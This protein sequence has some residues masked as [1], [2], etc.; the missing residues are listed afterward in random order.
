MKKATAAAVIFLCIAASPLRAFQLDD[1]TATAY[2]EFDL[3]LVDGILY[4]FDASRSFIRIARVLAT[5]L[6]VV[7]VVWNAFRLWLGTEQVRKACADIITKFLIFTA[8]FNLY[9][10]AVDGTVNMA[11]NIGMTAGGGY[12]YLAEEY[13]RL[14]KSC[15]AKVDA[16]KEVMNAVIAQNKDRIDAIDDKALKALADLTYQDPADLAAF[17]GEND[18]KAISQEQIDGA[19]GVSVDMNWAKWFIPGGFAMDLSAVGWGGRNKLKSAVNE[20]NKKITNVLINQFKEMGVDKA[21]S[22]LKAMEEVFQ[23][24]ETERNG[25]ITEEYFYNPYIKQKQGYSNLISPGAMI[26]SAAVI[27][28]I[29]SVKESSYYD[30]DGFKELN[31]LEGGIQRLLHFILLA[32]MSFGVIAAVVFF[33]VQYV[34]CIFEYFIVSAAGIIF[35][36]FCLWDGTK[37]FTAKLVTLFTAYFIKIMVMM[38]CIMWVF[39]AFLRMGNIIL[40]DSEGINFLNFSYFIFTL[41]LGW[42]VTQNGPQIAVT[43]LNGSPQLSMGEFM[44]AAGTAVG[45]GIAAGKMGSAAG[46]LGRRGARA[47]E[48]GALALTGAAAHASKTFEET[49]SAG[50]AAGAFF[51]KAGGYTASG[52]KNSAAKLITGQETQSHKD[53]FAVGS[54]TGKDGKPLTHEAALNRVLGRPDDYKKPEKEEKKNA[55][56]KNA[57]AIGGKPDGAGEPEKNALAVGEKPDGA[58]KP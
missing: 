46:N 41:L 22:T 28:Q 27:A 14:Y 3:P 23:I 6:G 56:E 44:H 38:L 5:L 7:C 51:G 1:L 24:T 29:L 16:A 34:M 43:L 48:T 53:G 47:A 32:L 19:A 42:A 55:A 12:Q 8:A 37:S 54:S 21:V 18:M 35:I 49:G 52:L 11:V 15:E 9:P 45:A 57:L 36:P 4:F 33:T 40:A 2:N 58:G 31:V 13:Y 39:G 20:A 30:S 26:K 10:A 17:L 50:K 25:V